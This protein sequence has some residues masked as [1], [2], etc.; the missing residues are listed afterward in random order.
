[1]RK[2]RRD[3]LIRV[4]GLVILLAAVMPNVLYLGHWSVAGEAHGG[5]HTAAEAEEHA[6]HCHLGPAKCS[7]QASFTWTW[8]IGDHEWSLAP[9][10]RP[11]QIE[12]G[13]YEHYA[14]PSLSIDTP[15]P[16][17]A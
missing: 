1:M 13:E 7:G 3:R 8:T 17:F 12:L 11:Q 10:A 14:E 15:P 4:G 6:A 2:L 16:R 5:I 9:N